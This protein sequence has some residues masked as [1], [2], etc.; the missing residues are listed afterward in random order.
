[1]NDEKIVLVQQL[2]DKSYIAVLNDEYRFDGSVLVEASNE[3]ELNAKINAAVKV[4]GIWRY[5]HGHPVYLEGTAVKRGH[6]RVRGMQAKNGKLRKNRTL[7][8]TAKV[9]GGSVV[10]GSAA[11]KDN[12]LVR[13]SVKAQKAYNKARK[14]EPK[15]TKDLVNISKALNMGMTGLKYSVK[16][17]SSVENKIRRKNKEKLP[18]YAVINKMGD[19]VRY[20]QM[21]KHS[22]LGKN[23]VKTVDALRKRGYKVTKI[24]NKY[25]DKTSDYKGIHLDCVSPDGQKF[26]LQMHSKESMAV[27]NKLHPIYEK[28]RNMKEGSP[29]RI[30]LE[31]QMREISATLPMPKGIDELKNYEER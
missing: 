14:A 11:S 8:A 13:S 2:K 10:G 16:T 30:A 21:G 4:D 31:N 17:A 3:E 7:A 29:E 12:V 19:L 22:D 24:D 15:I 5:I 18:D 27:K 25:L 6:A 26:E 23:A 20:T 1:M 9:N 28:S